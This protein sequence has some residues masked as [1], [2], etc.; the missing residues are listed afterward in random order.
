MYYIAPSYRGY[1]IISDD[2]YEDKKRYGII[3]YKGKEKKIRLWDKP[4]KSWKEDGAAPMVS[5]KVE[6]FHQNEDGSRAFLQGQTKSFAEQYGFDSHGFIW[7]FEAEDYGVSQIKKYI[8]ANGWKSIRRDPNLGLFTS[9]K[10]PPS[11]QGV[12]FVRINKEDV[13]ID[14]NTIRSDAEIKQIF[15][16]RGHRPIHII[17]CG[18]PIY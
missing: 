15:N 10:T 11:I 5:A 4:Q 12:T 6:K 1:K 3:D 16:E 9:L 18:R 2:I 17:S 8:E 13:L 14:D 7:F